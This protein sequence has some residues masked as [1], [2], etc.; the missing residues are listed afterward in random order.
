M[1]IT[2]TKGRHF[3]NVS[4]IASQHI[5]P[6]SISR[7][8]QLWMRVLTVTSL[9]T[10]THI[11]RSPRLILETQPSLYSPNPTNRIPAQ[12]CLILIESSGILLQFSRKTCLHIR[13]ECMQVF[14]MKIRRGLMRVVEKA[15]KKLRLSAPLEADHVLSKSRRVTGLVRLRYSLS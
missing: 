12:S 14:K 13:H 8:D 5:F 9:V 2:R 3:C 11:Q 4:Q 7:L 6:R 1:E 15:W 10:A